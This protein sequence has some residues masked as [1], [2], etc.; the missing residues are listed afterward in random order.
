MRYAD[1]RALRKEMMEAMHAVGRSEEYNNLPIIKEILHLRKA[2]ATLLGFEQFSDLVLNT[3]MTK[4]GERALNFVE[5]LF[6]KT[7]PF[8][9]EKFMNWKRTRLKSQ[10]MKWSILI[11]GIS[12]LCSEVR[13]RD[14]CDQ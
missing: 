2:K 14:L 13:A 9:N 8:L 7:K 11:H 6:V 3:R 10:V 12:L 4:T 5:D 1:D